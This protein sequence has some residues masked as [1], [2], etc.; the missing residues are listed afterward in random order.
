[1]SDRQE[2]NIYDHGEH[3]LTVYAQ[4]IS[5]PNKEGKRTLELADAFERKFWDLSLDHLNLI[6]KDLEND[7]IFSDIN[8]ATRFFLIQ[9]INKVISQREFMKANNAFRKALL[10]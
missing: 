2:I 5:A 4:D 9:T 10:P 3:V 6:I 7:T 1:M 8:R